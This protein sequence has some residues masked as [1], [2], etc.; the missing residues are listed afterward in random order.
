F[1]LAL[2]T[3]IVGEKEV[4]EVELD[5]VVEADVL[6]QQLMAQSPA[7]LTFTS[8]EL[9][10]QGTA[11]L[12]PEKVE[13]RIGIPADRA[14]ATQAKIDDLLSQPSYEITRPG[15]KQ[16]IDVRADLETLEIEN[17]T[18]R[19]VQRITRQAGFQPRE[20]LEILGLSDLEHQG[21]TIK[22]STITW[23][24]PKSP[25]PVDPGVSNGA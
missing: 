23:S 24:N 21:M 1:P 15:R 25:S 18:L 2:A 17:H 13:Y 20:L 19:F 8:V 5:E 4:M 7:G 12:Q 22:R 10:E 3:G 14:S 6:L 11:K 9:I 16:P